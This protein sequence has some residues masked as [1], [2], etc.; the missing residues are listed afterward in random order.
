MGESVRIIGFQF[1]LT[2][3]CFQRAGSGKKSPPHDTL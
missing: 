3:A 2:F 1:F